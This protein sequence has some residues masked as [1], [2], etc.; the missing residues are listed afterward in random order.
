[1]AKIHFLRKLPTTLRKKPKI[2][3][4][5]KTDF[6]KDLTLNVKEKA[7]ILRRAP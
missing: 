7:I 2:F 5:V 4:T 3:R 6:I 1:M